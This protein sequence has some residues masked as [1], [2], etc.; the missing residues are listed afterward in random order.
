MKWRTV[1]LIPLI[2]C[3]TMACQRFEKPTEREGL[4]NDSQSYS[5]VGYSDSRMKDAARNVDGVQDVLVD[6]NWDHIVVTVIPKP[7]VK[8]SEYPRI[9]R[10][11][12][13]E[14]SESN[15]IN[16]FRIQIKKANEVKP[17]Q[18]N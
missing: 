17:Y 10:Q 14:I 11:V 6:Y 4:D 13:K 3:L 5:Y 9:I 8:E 15:I 1:F 16:P 7:H 18:S 2:L 12:R